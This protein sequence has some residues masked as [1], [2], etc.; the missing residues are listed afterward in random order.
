[1]VSFHSFPPPN[2]MVYFTQTHKKVARFNAPLLFR[3]V[4]E[5][6]EPPAV[7]LSGQ[8]EEQLLAEFE[9]RGELPLD[10]L[11]GCVRCMLCDLC[12]NVV[13]SLVEGTARLSIHPSIHTFT[14]FVCLA[15]S[16]ALRVLVEYR[17]AYLMHAVQPLQEDG[18]A[19]R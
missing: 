11:L 13:D 6:A 1:M 16:L 3:V 15:A 18:R 7:V 5:V 12:R 19:V 2:G 17:P 10:L 14:H 8:E 9:G 4:P